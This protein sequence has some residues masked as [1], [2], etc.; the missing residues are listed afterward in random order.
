MDERDLVI[1][2]LQAELAVL[3]C[4]KGGTTCPVC[5]KHEQ[6]YRFPFNAGMAYM[7]V[8]LWRDFG[9][10]V[11]INLPVAE[12]QYDRTRRT[13]H[14]PKV[15]Y[16]GLAEM[17]EDVR[18]DGGKGPLWV[19]TEDMGRFVTGRLAIPSH[20]YIGKRGTFEGVDDTR[21]V[22]INDLVGKTFNLRELLQNRA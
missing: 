20:V 7:C 8:V 12:L 3:R 15:R 16:W 5:L 13:G 6:Q 22:R 18:A 9:P 21:T 11:E 4:Q 2:E 1:A 17:V 19:L 10:G 14:F